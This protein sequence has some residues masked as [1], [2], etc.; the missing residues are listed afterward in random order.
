MSVFPTDTWIF[1]L[2]NTL[3]PAE[4]ELFAQV[5]SR[6]GAYI[7][8]LLA[9]DATAA[10]ALQKTYYRQHGTT[11]RGLMDNH[12]VEP[13]D[14]LDYVHDID[15]S[16]LDAVPSLAA[17]LAALPGRRYVFTNGSR[18]HALQVLERLGLAPLFA[19]IFDIIAADYV[20]KPQALTYDRFI[21]EFDIDPTTAVFVED[22][23]AN[24]A[25][26]AALGMRTVWLCQREAP[27]SET[28]PDYVDHVID[29]LGQWL[30]AER[31]AGSISP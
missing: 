14:Y 27:G 13:E 3:Y 23:V 25:P 19:G 10:R 9:L 31:L 12:G 22:S 21:A 7:S 29:D 15:L 16:P 2:D 20:P 17:A 8:A 28:G 5:D 18:K 30:E 6:M 4:C 11:L 24:L 26:A 1:D